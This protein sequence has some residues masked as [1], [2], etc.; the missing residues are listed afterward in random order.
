MA[1]SM[2]LLFQP[3]RGPL[4]RKFVGNL[5]TVSSRPERTVSRTAMTDRIP[6][7]SVDSSLTE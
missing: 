2:R 4:M 5:Q 3:G 7:G 6:K 1:K